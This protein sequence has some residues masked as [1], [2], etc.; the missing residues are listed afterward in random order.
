MFLPQGLPLGRKL[1]QFFGRDKPK[2]AGKPE[3]FSGKF[4]DLRE[5]IISIMR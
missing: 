5:K 1:S 3:V 4:T 2:G